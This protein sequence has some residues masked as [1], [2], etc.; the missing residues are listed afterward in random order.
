M[1][2]ITNIQENANQNHS[3]NS[4]QLQWSLKRQKIDAGEDMEKGFLY[5]VGRNVT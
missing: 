2:N 1:P 5:T 3:T 4:S